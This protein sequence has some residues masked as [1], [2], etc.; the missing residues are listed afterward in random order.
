[1]TAFRRAY[2]IVFL[3]ILHILFLFAGLAISAAFFLGRR[4]R[5]LL[6]AYGVMAWARV[7]CL[8]LGLKVQTG[9]NCPRR[10]G[11]FIASNHCSYTDIP[12]I[13]SLIPSVFVSKAEVSSW[14]LFGWVARLG[15]TVFVRR[16]S[17][18]GTLS[19]VKDAQE[20]LT[21]GVNVVIFAEGTTDNGM[22]VDRFRSSFFKIPHEGRMP[23]LPLSIYYSFV[24]GAPAREG[25]VNEMAWHGMPLFSHFW[26]LISKKR[27]DV[28][29]FCN[30]AIGDLSPFGDRKA[31]AEEAY[32]RVREGFR[33]LREERGP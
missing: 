1:M 13:G 14:P 31:L 33:A 10:H 4:R 17:A 16:E 19:A 5:M 15:G 8:I 23:V 6:R 18:A 22:E 25:E 27:I 30:E 3:L 7:V 20:R 21:N 24:D 2:K 11:L 9:G 28:R 29:V 12:V 32:R 26:S